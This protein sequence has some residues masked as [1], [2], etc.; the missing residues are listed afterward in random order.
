MHLEDIYL[1]LDRPFLGAV[2]FVLGALV[3]SFINVVC[4]RLPKMTER[5]WHKECCE[6]LNIDSPEQESASSE[7]FNLAVP[8]SHCP[9][10]KHNIRWW[11]NIP[12]ISYLFL[13][14]RCSNCS[15]RISIR[16]PLVEFISACLSALVI[17]NTHSAEAALAGLLVTWFLLSMAII[18]FDTQFLLDVLT[19]PLLWFG[20]VIN[21]FS[22]FCPLQDAVI[23]AVAG[24][25]S[26]WV[27]NAL[28]KLYKGQ[29]GM[30]NGDFKLFA[31][32]GALLGWQYLP[33]IILLSSFAGAIVG[34]SLIL[35][36]NRDSNVRIPFGPYLASAGWIAMLWGNTIMHS[37]F[38]YT[39]M[40]I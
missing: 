31:A 36:Q 30:G 40:A 15:T 5:A 25:G 3:G 26:L 17:L 10:C 14:G 39:S 24:Y 38:T 27:I 28:F 22:V 20:L 34:I 4:F 23:G 12:L 2:A 13:K 7:T 18:D 11:E 32:L 1:Y 29:A 21:L 16:Y 9:H 35:V 19:Y 37:Y 8:N 33:L 6:F